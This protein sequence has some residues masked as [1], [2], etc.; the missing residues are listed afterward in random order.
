M[1][2]AEKLYTAEYK[3]KIKALHESVESGNFNDADRMLQELSQLRERSLFQELGKLTRQLHDTLNT[4]RLDK[5][6]VQL[7]EKEFP[8]TRERLKYVIH[9]T[10]ESADKSLTAAEAS[11]PLCKQLHQNTQKL[12]QL[13]QTQIASDYQGDNRQIESALENHFS[14][15]KKD[16][17]ELEK[18]L[19]NIILAQEY[20]DITGQIIEQVI[21]LVDDVEQSLVD[22]I[23]LSGTVVSSDKEQQFEEVQHG[24]YVPGVDKKDDVVAGQD[25]VDEL[26]SSLGF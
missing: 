17:P 26:L 8:D 20:Q 9:M 23:R 11:M 15:L 22:I 14:E 19:T 2:D 4:F 6:V 24:P 25:E 16:F 5:R 7:A 21:D 13:W 1:S 10:A 3:N 18:Q 12:Q